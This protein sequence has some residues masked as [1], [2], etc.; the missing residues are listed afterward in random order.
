MRRIGVVLILSALLLGIASAGVNM[1]IKKEDQQM[2]NDEREIQNANQQ[3]NNIEKQIHNWGNGLIRIFENFYRLFMRLS[4]PES[5]DK[6]YK[7]ST[8]EVP[9]S[10]WVGEMFIQA[11]AFDGMVANIQEGDMANATVQYNVFSSEYKNISRKVPE[12]KGYFDIAAV[13][14]LGKDLNANNV[15]AAYDDIGKVGATCEKC[16]FERTSQVWAKYYWRSFDTVNVTVSNK[17]MVWVDAMKA[18]A[19]GFGGIAANAAEGNQTAT[20]NS[21]KQFKQLFTNVRDACKNCHDTPRLYY[22]S[23]DVFEKID[24]MESNITVNNL[25]AVMANQQEFG[26]QCYRCHVLHWP[27]EEMKSKMGK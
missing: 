12:W 11:G 17:N 2:Q 15:P 24:Q 16:M 13:N 8:P 27:A 1:D 7:N 21:F 9:S 3:M 10:E 14:K 18:M 25:T 22:V 6:F 4:L 26:I 5:L 23:P 19:T 20:Y